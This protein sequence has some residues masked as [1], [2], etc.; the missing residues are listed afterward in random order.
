M[1]QGH[2]GKQV[3]DKKSALTVVNLRRENGARLRAYPCM[4]CNGW[5]VTHK[6][7]PYESER[8]K[9]RRGISRRLR[10]GRD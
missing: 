1:E 2:C 8:K 3:Y 5:H 9:P 10:Q 7:D 4:E 6:V